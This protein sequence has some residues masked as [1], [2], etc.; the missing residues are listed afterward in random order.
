M[1]DV[2]EAQQTQILGGAAMARIRRAPLAFARLTAMNYQI[3]L[4]RRS[5][6]PSRPR[7]GA[8]RV[9]RVAPAD[10]V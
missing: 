4:D 9:H 5:A 10:A 8:H 7:A 1:P 6:S 3:A 2:N